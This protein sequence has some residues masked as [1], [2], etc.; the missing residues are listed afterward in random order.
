MRDSARA[1][2]TRSSGVFSDMLC[3]RD[4]FVDVFGTGRYVR[5]HK[6]APSRQLAQQ[7]WATLSH[8]ATGPPTATMVQTLPAATHRYV[9][10][11]DPHRAG[12]STA[13]P[14]PYAGSARAQRVRGVPSPGVH[15]LLRMVSEQSAL[16]FHGGTNDCIFRDL[17]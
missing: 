8:Q 12:A 6:D 7:M 17:R 10:T 3:A 11:L 1:A 9:G 14:Q 4:W 5:A 16:R 13:P 15:S 2:H